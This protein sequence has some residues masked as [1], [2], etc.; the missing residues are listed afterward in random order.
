MLCVILISF[1]LPISLS[2]A[3]TPSMPLPLVVG[4]P[5]ETNIPPLLLVALL[6]LT[7]PFHMTMMTFGMTLPITTSTGLLA[8]LGL[9]IF[10]IY[11]ISFSSASGL[12]EG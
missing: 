9:L 12:A 11:L 4:K 8:T 2:L 5:E 1:P 3:C 10:H 7:P 6:Y